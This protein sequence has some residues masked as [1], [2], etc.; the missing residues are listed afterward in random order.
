[1]TVLKKVRKSSRNEL[2]KEGRDKIQV[3]N[4]I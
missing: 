3:I 1:M 4:K 2:W